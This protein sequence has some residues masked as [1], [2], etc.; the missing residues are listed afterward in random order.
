[1]PRFGSRFLCG[2]ALLLILAAP[3][4]PQ[5]S[6]GVVSGTVR[7]QSGAVIPTARV[8]LTNTATGIESKSTANEVGL[9]MFPGVVPGPHKLVTESPGLQ[10]FEATLTV[11]VQQSAVIDVTLNVSQTLTEVSVGDVTPLVTVD[12]PTLGHVLERQRIDQLPINGRDVNSLLVTVPGMEGSR[13]YGLQT[14]SHEMVLDGATLMD[15]L[16]GGNIR[17]PPG[18]D[19]IQE[20]KVENNNSSAKFTRPTTIILST[21]SGTNDFHGT[22]FETNRNNAYGKARGRTD[23]YEHA[24]TLIRNEFGAS[25]GGPV[26]LPRIYNGRNRTFFFGS[27]EGYRLVNP[28]TWAMTVPTRE[29]RNGDFRGLVDQQGRQTRIYDPWTTN[30]T[31]WERQLL[32]Y[33]GQANT[34]DPARMSPLA[35]YLYGITPLPTMPDVNPL[36]DD[37]W[38]GTAPQ[39]SRQWTVTTRLD[40]RFSDKDSFYGRYTQ[41][42]LNQFTQDW[43]GPMLDGVAG[44][45][46]RA[47]PNKSLA[48][49]WVRTFAPTFFNEV[50]ASAAREKWWKGTGQPGVKYSDKLGL[51]NP[52]GAVG[53]PGIYDSGLD[54]LFWETDNTQASPFAY[55]IFDDNAT[56][57][58]GT[59]ELQFGFHFRYDQLNTLPDQQQTQG[60]HSFA[61]AYTTLYDPTS[62]RTNPLATPLTGSNAA[63]MFLGLMNYS[64]NFNRGYFYMRSRE[65]A[66][67]LQDNWKVTSRLT[68]NLGLRWEFWPANRE[69]NNILTSFDKQKRAIVLGQDL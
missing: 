1:M 3:C 13:A 66:L 45:V 63:N 41:G 23:F 52:F 25:A 48:L 33:R 54:D 35:K 44:S 55:F 43:N 17:R 60:N 53:W 49:S 34:I 8:S 68:L 40:H 39:W 19:T 28:T 15:R 62:S 37:N 26:I 27:Y 9:Y 24:P 10:R 38:W 47:A 31:T 22:A 20:F 50:V 65:Y 46:T 56:K 6:T 21:R 32:T 57:I 61:S 42:D 14:G 51:P 29:M 16:W 7:D 2:A 5:A 59:H 36:Y 58:R 69:K 64:N 18:L 30:T 67:Y 11:Q 4:H 12:N